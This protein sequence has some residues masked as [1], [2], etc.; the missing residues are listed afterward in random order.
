MASATELD[1]LS[2]ASKPQVLTTTKST[3]RR[4]H[5]SLPA[6]KYALIQAINNWQKAPLSVR[7]QSGGNAAE[8]TVEDFSYVTPTTRFRQRLQA[9]PEMMHHRQP[10]RA[11]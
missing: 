7:E 2:V 10:A 9:S 1:L 5:N 11:K 6:T 3:S 8:A 4:T